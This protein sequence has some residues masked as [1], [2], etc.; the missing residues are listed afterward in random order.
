MHVGETNATVCL[1]VLYLYCSAKIPKKDFSDARLFKIFKMVDKDKSRRI[2]L[3]EFFEWY[4]S[5]CLS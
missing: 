1:F 5:T 4:G 3:S 2:E